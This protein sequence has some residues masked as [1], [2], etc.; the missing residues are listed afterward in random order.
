MVNFSEKF[1][2]AGC[3]SLSSDAPSTDIALSKGNIHLVFVNL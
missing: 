2:I 3:H 1:T